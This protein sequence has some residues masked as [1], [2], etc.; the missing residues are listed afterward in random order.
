[1]TLLKNP[2]RIRLVSSHEKSKL[3]PTPLFL[4]LAAPSL[5]Y[6]KIRL[7]SKVRK[8]SAHCIIARLMINYPA[9][10]EPSV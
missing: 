5:S 8:S 1:M 4:P 10:R 3:N 9:T 6:S 7:I 2:R